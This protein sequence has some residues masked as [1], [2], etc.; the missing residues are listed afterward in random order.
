[1]RRGFIP[2]STPDLIRRDVLTACGFSPR[3][4][5]PQTYFIQRHISSHNNS[6]Q[7]Q[8]QASSSLPE[9]EDGDQL[10]LTATSEFPLAAMYA[11]EVLMERN[12][13]LKMVAFGHCFRAEGLAGSLN[14][15][16]YRVHQF[17]KVEM[18]SIT[19]PTQSEAMMQEFV[20][21]QRG[22]FENLGL[23]FR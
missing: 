13:P 19:T 3:S 15:G 16:L 20:D 6:Y 12:L 7:Q 8:Q 11:N 22:L 17:S 1:M 5:D 18:F 23:C 10:C 4:D 21:V 14:R 9:E 2:V